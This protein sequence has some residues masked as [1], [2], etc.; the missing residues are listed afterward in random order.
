[1]GTQSTVSLT[2]YATTETSNKYWTCDVHGT[3]VQTI[4]GATGRMPHKRVQMFPSHEKARH[5]YHTAVWGK[6]AKGYKPRY[7]DYAKLLEHSAPNAPPCV[8]ASLCIGEYVNLSQ[9]IIEDVCMWITTCLYYDL[10][11]LRFERLWNTLC[12]GEG[13]ETLTERLGRTGET[14]WLE[15]ITALG[16]SFL[17]ELYSEAIVNQ[18]DRMIWVNIYGDI[19]LVVLR[20]DP[21]A[22]A[23][24]RCADAEYTQCAE[25]EWPSACSSG[26]PIASMH[27]LGNPDGVVLR[28][29][30]VITREEVV[31]PDSSE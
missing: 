16:E 5:A 30:L 7:V 4:W 6:L 19:S 21:G 18:A 1:M 14:Y 26:A 24:E 28:N 12:D 29:G 31:C 20:G 23:I 13:N 22:E 3:T 27:I 2:L 25:T 10:S 8:I 11:P 17:P 15:V 9:D